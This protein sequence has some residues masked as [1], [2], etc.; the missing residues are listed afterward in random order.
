M[1]YTG[2]TDRNQK[3]LIILLGITDM[4]PIPIRGGR[5]HQKTLASFDIKQS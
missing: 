4:Y 2:K 3:A 5:E 1:I